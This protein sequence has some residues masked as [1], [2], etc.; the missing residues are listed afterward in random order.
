M[1]EALDAALKGD[2]E[3]P[4]RMNQ[5]IT[6][7][8]HPDASL[9]LMPAWRVGQR[10]GVK[11][12]TVFPGNRSRNERAVAAVYA[13]FDATTARRSHFS[14]ARIDGAPNGGCIGYA[15]R[16]LARDDAHH[17]VMVG[18]GRLARGS[19]EA[20][21]LVRDI[22]RISL[23]SRTAKHAEA[24]AAEMARDGLPVR[25]C[26]DLEAAVH[27]A[28][29]VCARRSRR[30][31]WSMANGFD[32]AR[33]SI[34]SVRSRAHMRETDDALMRR[35]DLIVVDDREAALAEGG[36]VVQAIASGAISGA[37]IVAE[38][39][40]FAR[41]AHRGRTRAGEITVFKSVGFALEDWPLPRRCSMPNK[42]LRGLAGP[43]SA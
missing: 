16:R 43:A 30:R 26:S 8:G 39:R 34:W 18:A 41:G 9:L 23:W 10:I 29:I 25:A 35:A 15:A 4:L 11:L 38:L 20:H 3:A 12:V 2:A 7:P 1:L 5:T 22:D 21:S 32:P 19:I 13:L 27:E 24:A 14:M 33:T 37:D 40:D 6:V 31:R 42:R 36:D 28:D 17:L